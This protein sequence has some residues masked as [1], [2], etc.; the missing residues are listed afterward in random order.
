MDQLAHPNSNR[1]IYHRIQMEQE[2]LYMHKRSKI[3]VACLSLLIGGI[4]S[5]FIL[6]FLFGTSI[7]TQQGWKL[8]AP[9][10]FIPAIGRVGIVN[11]LTSDAIDAVIF[12]AVIYVIVYAVMWY[13]KRRKYP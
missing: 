5:G 4:L 1:M 10:S 2:T 6:Q 12:G 13:S 11:E 8:L 3:I 7:Y 9:S